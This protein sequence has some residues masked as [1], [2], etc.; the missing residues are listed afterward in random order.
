MTGFSWAG[1][2]VVGDATL[3]AT[4]ANTAISVL[5]DIVDI[6][7]NLRSFPAGLTTIFLD[8]SPSWEFLVE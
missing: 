3:A 8:T 6:F 7:L 2:T 4:V 1:G 5:T